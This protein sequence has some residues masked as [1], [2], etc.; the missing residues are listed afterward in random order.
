MPKKNIDKFTK[1]VATIGPA[2]EEEDVIKGL[3][4]AGMNV[5]RF[6]TKHSEPVWH[7]ERI[8]RVRKVAGEMGVSVGILLDLQGPEIRINLPDEKPFKIKV[9]ETV[10]FTDN[11]QLDKNNLILIPRKV[12]NEVPVDATILLDD[13]FCEFIV[14]EKGED[15]LVAQALTDSEVKHRKTM[16][17]PGI[18]I[19]MPSLIEADYKQLDGIKNDQINFV[20][21]SFVRNRADIDFLR[22]E[23]KKRNL[24]ADV[25]SKIETQ[26]ALD[27]L[28]E[29]IEA[30][31]AVMIARGD[32]AVEV[33]YE[34]LVYWQ[35]T[36]IDM[37][38]VQEKPV[39]TATQMLKSMTDSPRP[40]RA[41]VSDVAHA[42][43]DCT[44]AVMLSEETT[45]G[46]YPV[47]AVATQAKIAD[48]NEPHVEDD[49]FY[50]Q[51]IQIENDQKAICS[52]VFNLVNNDPEAYKAIVCL[53]NTGKTARI[54][55]SY[56]PE[57]PI[58][59]ITC[60]PSTAD[61]LSLAYAI[62]PHLVEKS[63]I[64]DDNVE[65][66]IKMLKDKKLL[67]EG[68]KII[69]TMSSIPP[70]HLVTN[71]MRILTI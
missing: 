44:S 37:C 5:A 9:G 68:D 1:I 71:E 63:V 40:T 43:Y 54:L 2:T 55:A 17:I 32:L 4:E 7:Q 42:I 56:R 36:I 23:L 25:V 33:D 15:Y 13:G 69:L 21:L 48:F 65:A 27:N 10:F 11:A 20:A 35:K 34:E 64:D 6:N 59:A 12:I 19:D 57:I 70:Q 67:S 28:N 41:E 30:S 50:C 45:I 61:K 53:S 49:L 8:R 46:K 60:H 38:R 31:D 18:T 26:A 29:I 58:H 3:I 66:V 39:I 47:K 51:N 14:T 24:T 62:T 52:S 16:N 22:E